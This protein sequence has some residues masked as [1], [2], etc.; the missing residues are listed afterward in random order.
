VKADNLAAA[1]RL[2]EGGAP[3]DQ[4]DKEGL[5]PL[6]AL[7]PDNTSDWHPED[8]FD[9][10]RLLRT[11]ASFTNLNGEKFM[12]YAEEIIGDLIR[13]NQEL[14]WTQAHIDEL[15]QIMHA[16]A[17]MQDAVQGLQAQVA[18]RD[19]L[20]RAGSRRGAQARD[21]GTGRT[22]DPLGSHPARA[23]APL[24]AAG[25]DASSIRGQWMDG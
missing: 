11:A 24:N 23:Q 19:G 25:A 22:P 5:T 13:E 17:A 2:V 1:R 14:G 18:G 8:F 3:V 10:V 16:D 6:F 12:A 9:G 21:A 20:R 15:W 4:A 7:I